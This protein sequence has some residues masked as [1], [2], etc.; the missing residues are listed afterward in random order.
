MSHHLLWYTFC[1]IVDRNVYLLRGSDNR[2]ALLGEVALEGG[3]NGF[4]WLDTFKIHFILVSLML[5]T[6][7]ILSINIKLIFLPY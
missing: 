1:I 5:L 6:R 2:P 4:L 7:Y 3:P